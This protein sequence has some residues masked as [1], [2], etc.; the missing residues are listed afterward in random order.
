MRILVPY[1]SRSGFTHQLATTLAAELAARG[2]EVVLERIEAV[3]ERNKW[4]LIP[5]LLPLLPFL[6]IYLLHA[7]FRNWWLNRYRQHEQDI[8]P[9]SHPDVSGY[10][11]ILLGGPKWLYVSFPVAR[12]LKIVK[13]MEGKKVGA[14]ATFCG[15]PLEVFEME[16]LFRPLKD[17]INAKGASVIDILAIS[18][19]YHPFFFFG[20]M[21]GIFRWISKKAFNRPLSEFTLDSDWGKKEVKRFCDGI[22]NFCEV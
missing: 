3:Q 17:R 15:P 22:E 12:Y 2:H 19:N 4:L 20:E 14:F 5:P 11:M 6:P 18:S 8:K 7:P 10:D 1:Y 16:M 9:L 21:E 13:G